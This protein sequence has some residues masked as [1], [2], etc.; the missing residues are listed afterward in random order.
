MNDD[1]RKTI[2]QTLTIFS[3]GVVVWIAFIF[4]NACGFSLACKRGMPAVDGTPIPTLIPA[5]MPAMDAH[6]QAESAE[7]KCRVAAADLIGAWVD[8]GAPEADS[9][10]FTAADGASCEATFA[11]VLPLFAEANLWAAGAPSCDSC[12]SADFNSSKAKLDLTSYAGIT[13]GSQRADAESK[14][15]DILGSA[16]KSSLLYQFMMEAKEG[17]KGHTA[18]V[19]AAFIYAGA[20]LPVATPTP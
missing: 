16:W 20:P 17:V 1:V 3:V 5:A 6:P 10:P 7:G 15:T 8:A 19:S 2:Y 9:F 14:G 12:H 13:A 11:D 4:L 18:P